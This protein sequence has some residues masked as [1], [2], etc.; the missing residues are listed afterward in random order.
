MKA[1]SILHCRLA[2]VTIKVYF[3]HITDLICSV[4]TCMNGALIDFCFGVTANLVIFFL[5]QPV[6]NVFWSFTLSFRILYARVIF[7]DLEIALSGHKE[8]KTPVIKEP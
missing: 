3:T 8:K 2:D 5:L 7:C 4:F 6:F 1:I